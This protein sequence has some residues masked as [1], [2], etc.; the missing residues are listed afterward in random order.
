AGRSFEFVQ[1]L[2]ACSGLVD[3]TQVRRAQTAREPRDGFW[4][5]ETVPVEGSGL[6]RNE[7]R[8]LV[9]GASLQRVTGLCR[10]QVKCRLEGGFQT[11]GCAQPLQLRGGRIV[12]AFLEI[13]IEEVLD[14]VRELVPNELSVVPRWILQ[15]R[16]RRPQVSSD[17][18][19]PIS[20]PRIDMGW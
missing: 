20:E 1:T 15:G 3:F 4:P 11:G 10:R 13:G 5:G 9:P 18:P 2:A 12:R 7:Q 8:S 16:R 14:R 6:T 17:H 19:L